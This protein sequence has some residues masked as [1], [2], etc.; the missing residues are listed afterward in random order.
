MIPLG[1]LVPKLRKVAIYTLLALHF[2]LAPMGFSDFSSLGVL[3]AWS[4]VDLERLEHQDLLK[5][6]GFLAT[7]CLTMQ[8]YFAPSRIPYGQESYEFLEGILFSF[9]YGLFAFKYIVRNIDTRPLWFPKSVLYSAS[10]V[11]LFIFGFS[12]YLG[13]RT[14]GNF[15]MFSN[16]RTEGQVSNHLILGSNPFKIFNFQEDVVKV[17]SVSRNG[18]GVYRRMPK[19][20]QSIP[21]IEFDRLLKK[22]KFRTRGKGAVAMKVEYQGKE[23][24]TSN[25]IFDQ[26]FR[27]PVPPWQTKLF[28]F[29]AIQ[30]S[31]RQQCA[32]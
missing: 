3:L 27:F 26:A 22:M 24:Q 15:S 7:F 1:L 23:Y 20:G 2:M 30:S 28:K 11:C 31:S 8:L 9:V 5:H 29:R 32:W 12:N 19:P 17:L 14:A 6:V 13:L 4:F 21:R 10:V 18:R 25:A 16:L